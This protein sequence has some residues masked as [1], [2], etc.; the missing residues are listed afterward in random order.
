MIK[1]VLFDMDGTLLDSEIVALKAWDY[2]IE[3]YHPV[4]DPTL[5]MQSI[6]LNHNSMAQLFYDKCGRDFPF[7]TYWNSA[8]EFFAEY[9]MTHPLDI[10]MGFYEL[11]DYLKAQGIKMYIA[12]STYHDTAVKE[13]EIAG[14]WQYFDGL[15]GGDEIEK[16]KPHPE[17]YLKA[18]ALAGC[19]ID[20]CLVIEDSEN[21]IKSG[22][23][24][25]MKCVFIKD[26]KDISPEIKKNIYRECKDLK[27]VIAVIE[28]IKSL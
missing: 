7:E 17:I 10:K 3:K 26:I 22:I 13:L 2:I 12:T 20:S 18:S 19:D 27:E 16:G 4:M 11:C 9:V 24:A 6:G 14:I 21:G 5:P 15:I 1:A 8:T 28:D 25:G 23:N